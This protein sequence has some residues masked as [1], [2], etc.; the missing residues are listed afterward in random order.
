MAQELKTESEKVG[1]TVNL[2]KT[3]MMTND[4]A[5]VSSMNNEIELVDEYKYLGR[6][7]SFS[8]RMNKEIS[9]RITNGWKAFWSLKNVFKGKMELSTKKKI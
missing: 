1:F 8:D 3:K 6:I 2:S 9:A 4:E 5:E 7:T